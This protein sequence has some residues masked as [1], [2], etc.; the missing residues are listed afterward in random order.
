MKKVTNQIVAIAG[1]LLCVATSHAQI[2]MSSGTLADKGYEYHQNFDTLA[3][4]GTANAWAENSTLLGWY[5]ARQIGGVFTV[6]RGEA[7]AGNAG[8]LYSFGTNGINVITDRAFGT[9]GSGTPGTQTFGVRLTNDTVFAQSNIIVSFTGEQWRNGGNA[10]AQPLA[11]Y[12]QVSAVGVSIQTA[13]PTTNLVWTGFSGLNF[14]SPSVGTVAMALDGNN[15]T[16]RIVFTN[17]VLNGVVVL[18]GQELFLRW[19]DLNDAGNDHGLAIDDLTVSFTNV[20]ASATAASIISGPANVTVRAGDQVNSSVVAGGTT[21]LYYNWFTVSGGVTN[22][23]G[24]VNPQLLYNYASSNL[25]GSQF[26]VV[27]TNDLGG[28]TSALASIT[29][30][31]VTPIATNI[32]YLRKLRTPTY[33]VADP[34]NLFTIEGVVIT[35]NLLT[36]PLQSY[37]VWDGTNGMDVFN[38]DGGFPLPAVGDMVRI[39][40]PLLNFNG[41]LELNITN[42]NPTHTFVNLS[43]GNALPT[44]QFFNIA[45]AANPVVMEDSVEGSLVILTNVF[46]GYTNSAFFAAGTTIFTTNSAGNSFNISIPS[47]TTGDMVNKTL[48]TPPFAATVRGVISQNSQIAVPTNNYSLVV[49]TYSDIVWTNNVNINTPLT[50][51]GGGTNQTISWPLKLMNLYTATNVEGPYTVIPGATSP[52]TNDA[53]TNAAQF[54]KLVY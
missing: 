48:Q 23:I 25:T 29:V 12:Y 33:A 27:V 32:S 37:F 38:R 40:G 20:I 22:Y 50:V 45:T 41:L 19:L 49:F 2:L 52:Y 42:A 3:T 28:V 13:D 4:S 6:Y 15:A 30:T 39:T 26:F 21:P 35:P 46:L 17:T 10:S 24:N 8:A 51:S 1:A 16:N 18:P 43:S 54:F 53:T 34:T 5:A 11:F 14:V 44:P 9:A 31:G 7:G 36:A 47:D